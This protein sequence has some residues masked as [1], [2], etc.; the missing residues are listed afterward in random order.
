MEITEKAHFEALYNKY[1]AW[2]T[3]QLT[4]TDGYSYEKSFVTFCE[5]FNKELF[6]LSV[7]VPDGKKK[8]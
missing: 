8:R 2:K 7:A 4:Q 5:E 1:L 6:E 3:S